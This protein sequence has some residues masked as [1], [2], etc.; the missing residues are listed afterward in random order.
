MD[1]AENITSS[2]FQDPLRLPV[3]RSCARTELRNTCEL[4]F[5]LVPRRDRYLYA[6]ACVARQGTCPGLMQAL[7]STLRARP[8]LPV[9]LALPSTSASAR[10]HRI[11]VQREEPPELY[12]A[13]TRPRAI[14]PDAPK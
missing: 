1:I 4:P 8:V 3:W 6:L 12:Q 7:S 9:P 11:L 5:A 10:A 2:V 14:P 13:F